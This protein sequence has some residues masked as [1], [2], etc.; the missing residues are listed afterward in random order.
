MQCTC[1]AE[2]MYSND[3]N[4]RGSQVYKLIH[5]PAPILSCFRFIGIHAATTCKT[6]EVQDM[7]LSFGR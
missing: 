7:L 6:A 2:S 5:Y 3:V 4:V 1:V